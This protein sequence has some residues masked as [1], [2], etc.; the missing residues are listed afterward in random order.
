MTDSQYS[1]V[2]P[3]PKSLSIF[4]EKIDPVHLGALF[5]VASDVGVPFSFHVN[6][7]NTYEEDYNDQVTTEVDVQVE[8]GSF[9]TLSGFSLD[10]D[11]VETPEKF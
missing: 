1:P 6:D 5:S 11:P 2:A 7:S 3:E 8:E 10:E 9:E 4:F